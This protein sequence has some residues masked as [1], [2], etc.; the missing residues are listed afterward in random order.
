MDLNCFLKISSPDENIRSQAERTI[1]DASNN[2]QFVPFLLESLSIPEIQKQSQI[3]QQIT[4]QILNSIREHFSQSPNSESF[5]NEEVQLNISSKILSYIPMFQEISQNVLIECFRPII[6][7]TFPNSYTIFSQV[8]SMMEQS[9]SDINQLLIAIQI[10]SFWASSCSVLKGAE[11]PDSTATTILEK[12]NSNLIA[13]LA[14]IAPTALQNITSGP[15]P[16]RLI[17]QIAYISR[18]LVHYASKPH[19]SSNF[20][21]ILQTL[22]SFLSISISN[23]E[24]ESAKQQIIRLIYSIYNVFFSPTQKRFESFSEE[25]R[26]FS[27]HFSEEIFPSLLSPIV[28]GLTTMTDYLS[29]SYGGF[30]LSRY[31]FY[32]IW[33]PSN[34]ILPMN[35]L[36]EL[37]VSLSTLNDEEICDTDDNPE[38]FISCSIG[39]ESGD[40]AKS[41]RISASK[42][43]GALIEKYNFGS[44]LFTAFSSLPPLTD[45]KLLD[46]YIFLLMEVIKEQRHTDLANIAKMH[47]EAIDTNNKEL[48]HE[49]ATRRR[50]MA[51]QSMV[52]EELASSI[53]QIA[54]SPGI[55]SYLQSTSLFFLSSVLPR[56]QPSFG[57]SLGASIISGAQSP[58]VIFSGA[59]LFRRCISK[60]EKITDECFDPNTMIP[61]LLNISR[62]F[63]FK[64]VFQTIVEAYKI[65]SANYSTG[66]LDLIQFLFESADS[67]MNND[68][69][70]SKLEI[71]TCVFR[72][73]FDIVDNIPENNE[74]LPSLAEILIKASIEFLQKYQ[75]SAV[76]EDIIL[77]LANISMKLKD[78]IPTQIE[79]IPLLLDIIS[80]EQQNLLA[81]K[82]ISWLLYPIIIHPSHPIPSEVC[83][84]IQDLVIHGFHFSFTPEAEGCKEECRAYAFLLASCMVQAY[85]PTL[86]VSGFME[87]TMEML[88]NLME[89]EEEGATVEIEPIMFVGVV[90]FFTALVLVD[91]SFVS[92]LGEKKQFFLSKLNSSVLTTYREMKMGEIILQIIASSGD[93]Q[94]FQQA[95]SLVPNLNILKKRDEEEIEV[96]ND[97]EENDDDDDEIYRIVAPRKMPLDDYNEGIILRQNM[98]HYVIPKEI[99]PLIDSMYPPSL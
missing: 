54:T 99:R 14:V 96:S 90:Y 60:N 83:A 89:A 7:K 78:P 82:Y 97:E 15:Q 18:K 4:I 98:I 50:A 19:S 64:D 26:S 57:A 61:Q 41:P 38:V 40:E 59:H 92:L 29:R 43:I 91:P 75:N 93:E 20:T 32:K 65:G 76:F 11:L 72:L 94:A 68:A 74:V 33:S 58:S 21:T 44:D 8:L 77:V 63:H 3:V 81:M 31:I 13:K 30:L 17:S 39:Y 86:N 28:E 56:I 73:L 34:K 70:R 10:A 37:L 67:E 45:T 48:R 47:Q 23:P 36:L 22:A 88:N 42:I 9:T 55:P 85:G 84:S 46:A 52:P 24:F 66:I 2:P 62:T 49:A 69:M 95:V 5:W 71:T 12:S 87:M 53:C 79:M 16:V 27:I 1:L 6:S 51:T 25:Q 80:K 35:S